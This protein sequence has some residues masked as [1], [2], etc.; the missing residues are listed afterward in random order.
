[1]IVAMMLEQ[2]DRAPVDLCATD[3]GQLDVFGT[4]GLRG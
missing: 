3:S 4:V 2:L 1:M